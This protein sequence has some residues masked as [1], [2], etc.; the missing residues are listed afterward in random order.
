[1]FKIHWTLVMFFF[2]KPQQ[3]L[4]RNLVRDL[5]SRL[6]RKYQRNGSFPMDFAQLSTCFTPHFAQ[7]SSRWLQNPREKIRP[8]NSR[9]RGIG[10]AGFRHIPISTETCK[11][12]AFRVVQLRWLQTPPKGTRTNGMLQFCLVTALNLD[13]RCFKYESLVISIYR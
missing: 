2:S 7:P 4:S 8:K 9:S 12:V 3:G 10:M 6:G 13:V 5:W 11:F 1:M